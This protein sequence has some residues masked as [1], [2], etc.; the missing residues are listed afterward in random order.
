MGG[1]EGAQCR[2]VPDITP[3]QVTCLCCVLVP[4]TVF[5]CQFREASGRLYG[6]HNVLLV[7]KGKKGEALCGIAA[8]LDYCEKGKQESHTREC[9]GLKST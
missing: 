9:S 7:K 4:S 6:E 2:L 5:P 3:V 8:T 1:Q